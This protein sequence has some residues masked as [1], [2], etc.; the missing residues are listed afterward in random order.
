[1]SVTAVASPCVGTFVNPV[2]DICWSCLFPISIGPIAVNLSEQRDITNPDM[3]VCL[4]PK[5][6]VPLVPGIAMG[7]WE[8]VRLIDVTRTPYCLVNLGGLQL[9]GGGTQ[10]HGDQGEQ[11]DYHDQYSF[12]QVHYYVYPVIYW[13]ELL[14]DFA[15]LEQST[16][17]VAYMSELDPMWNNDEW[18]AV[19]NPE[20]HL[21]ASPILQA[22]CSAD[23]LKATVDFPFDK[24]FWCAGCQGALYPFTGHMAHHQGGV[25]SSLLMVQKTLAKLHRTGLAWCTS[26]EENLCSKSLCPIVKKSQ[27]KTQMTYPVALNRCDPLGASSHAWVAN[28]EYPSKGED[29]GYLL[30]RKKNCCVL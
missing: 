29:F 6:P 15:C 19:V 2:T 1:M 23:C 24:L 13:L 9:G 7:F 30:W 5:P 20:A 25:D 26:G 3:P 18:N 17:D 14:T 11:S 8:P 28:K 22:A 4:C 21:F 16:L 10:G 27:Y 12:Y